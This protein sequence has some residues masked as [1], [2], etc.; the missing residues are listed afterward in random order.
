MDFLNE[1]ME[2]ILAY[3]DAKA[4]EKQTAAVKD[5]LKGQVLRSK[6]RKKTHEY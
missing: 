2:L 6:T 1:D 3:A 5:E 4:K